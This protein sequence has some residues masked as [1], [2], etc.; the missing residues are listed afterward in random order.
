MTIRKRSAGWLASVTVAAEHH[1]AAVRLG[2][3]QPQAERR[4]L[5][6]RRGDVGEVQR[7]VR[8]RHPEID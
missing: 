5:P 7:R 6:H 4:A 8:Q 1:D 3:R 2:Q